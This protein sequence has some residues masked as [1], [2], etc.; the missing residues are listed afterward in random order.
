MQTVTAHIDRAP[1]ALVQIGAF[2]VTVELPPG[3]SPGHPRWA[4]LMAKSIAAG[5]DDAFSTFPPKAS[6]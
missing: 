6:A 3:I 5:L 4:P 1:H 2:Q